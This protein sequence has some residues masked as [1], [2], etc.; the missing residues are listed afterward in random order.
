MKHL[1]PLYRKNV[2]WISRRR[3]GFVNSTIKIV[4]KQ[5][6]IKNENGLYVKEGL[7][8]IRDIVHKIKAL[9]PA[10]LKFRRTNL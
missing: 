3:E 9:K 2:V 7:K 8:K 6:I 1:V 10:I 5:L 4:K